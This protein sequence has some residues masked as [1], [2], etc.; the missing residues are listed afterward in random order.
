[1]KW[2]AKTV[3]GCVLPA[4]MI[5]V[6]TVSVMRTS[7]SCHDSQLTRSRY[8]EGRSLKVEIQSKLFHAFLGAKATLNYG[9]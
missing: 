6:V 4:V 8:T 7:S 5:L 3:L 9:H 1:M 2:R